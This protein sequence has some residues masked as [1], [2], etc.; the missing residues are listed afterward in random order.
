MDASGNVAPTVIVAGNDRLLLQLVGELDALGE[1]TVFLVPPDQPQLA[2]E[3]EELGGRV[4]IGLAT[5]P[6]VL[7]DAGIETAHAF[8][9]SGVG[10]DA[11]VHAAFA[12]AK[13]NPQIRLVV[14]MYNLRLG[15]RIEKLFDDC[16][17]LSASAI[18]AP[19]F[20]D[21][22]TGAFTTQSVLAGGRRVVIGSPQEVPALVP[23]ATVGEQ[24]EPV[25]LSSTVDGSSTGSPCI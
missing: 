6:Y 2:R 22:A 1:S 13:L 3:A 24:G 25:L 7:R 4:I 12:A 18:A 11:N 19:L 14:R 8:A 21:A 15:K 5:D 17:V 10:D 20:V 16:L 9:I 23:L